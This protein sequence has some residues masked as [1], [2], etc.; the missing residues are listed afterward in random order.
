M[1]TKKV[2]HLTL[3]ERDR[4]GTISCRRPALEAR[5]RCSSPGPLATFVPLLEGEVLDLLRRHGVHLL[6]PA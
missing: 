3:E 2:E 1:T 5:A 6:P 4:V